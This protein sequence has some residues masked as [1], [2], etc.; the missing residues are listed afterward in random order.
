MIWV[1]VLNL[2]LLLFGIMEGIYRVQKSKYFIESGNL[3]EQ[4]NFSELYN[5]VV[6]IIP[7]YNEQNVIR[8]SV[9]NFKPLMDYGIKVI[10]VAT[11]KEKAEITTYALLQE[12][13]E[14][15]QLSAHCKV[16]LYPKK[17]GVMAHQLNYAVNQI[18]NNKIVVIYNVDSVVDR[19]TINYILKHRD[20]LEK[21]VFQQ[22]SYSAYDTKN[23]FMTSAVMWQNR[24]STAYELPRTIG[25]FKFGIHKFNYVIGH[26]L[27]LRK[28]M[29][30]KIG[31]FSED[32]INEDNVL[33]YRL[34]TEQVS[35]CP[36]PVLEKIDFASDLKI[37]VRQQSVWFNGPFY[38]FHYFIQLRKENREKKTLPLFFAA[39]QN[40]KNALNWL[41]FP[42]L[43]VFSMV[44]AVW[45]KD[46]VLFLCIFLL[47]IG[48]VA[49]INR[50]S[51]Q[52]LL[53][54]GYLT[55][56]AKMNLKYL[57]S[58]TVFWLWIHSFGPLITIYKIIVRKNNQKNKYKTE[59]VNY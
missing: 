11:A 31:G 52:L 58:E 28:E 43:T 4:D 24:W 9:L 12:L 15:Y 2:F 25:N 5:E 21:G 34:H 23:K 10:Y 1:I 39:C 55:D 41:F 46:L 27:A 3:Q 35:V 56:K 45:I 38:A 54:S 37:Y 36:I 8:Q 47:L 33:G 20:K 50:L 59:K 42:Y 40:F 19:K 14:E 29:L 49:G 7:V 17:D 48:Y 32:Q 53:K 13:I 44:Y 57:F 22:Y 16:L 6:I 51:E 30:N 18:E 26:G